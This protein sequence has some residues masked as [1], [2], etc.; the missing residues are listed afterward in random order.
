MNCGFTRKLIDW[1]DRRRGRSVYPAPVMLMGRAIDDRA[2]AERGSE[3]PVLCLTSSCP[4]ILAP[5][6]GM[7]RVRAIAEAERAPQG[8]KIAPSSAST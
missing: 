2:A 7:S 1:Q 4:E 6:R 8:E 3:K 5:A